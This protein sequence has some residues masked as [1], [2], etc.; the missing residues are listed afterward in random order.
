MK[1]LKRV[2]TAFAISTVAVVAQAAPI[3]I[4][5]DTDVNG[6]VVV[7]GA[8]LNSAYSGLG[9]TFNSTARV[10]VGGGGVTSQPNFATGGATD[11]TTPLEL[12]F[13]TFAS[14]VGAANVFAS[15]FT[16][17]AFDINGN[18][19]GSVNSIDFPGAVSLSGLGDIKSA[20]FSTTNQYGIDDLTFDTVTTAAV[21]EP[22][23]IALV[24]L[25]LFGFAASRRK[26][27]K[28][29]NA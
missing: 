12:V 3:T 1:L 21:P 9:A 4:N 13:D 14:S 20:T 18:V 8:L 17:T 7:N 6:A 26:S 25:G 16:L 15:S 19:L 10:V 2:A 22:G 23:S 11:L 5:F 27:A 28:S 29:K 24:G